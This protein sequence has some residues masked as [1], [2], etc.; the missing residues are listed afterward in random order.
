MTEYKKPLPSPMPWSKPFWDG[1]SQGKLLVQKCKACSR[2]VFYPKLFC[3]FC[4]SQEL[5]WIEAKG[6]GKVYTFTVVYAYQPTEFSEDVP[7]IV[8]V[9]D[10]D[11]GVR[12]MSNIVDC[13]PEEVRCDMEV[14]VVFEKATEE[15]TFPKFRPVS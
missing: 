4:L 5:E 3:P 2:P 1:C 12:L 8:A 13:K 6:T 15:V 11:E 9:I 14:E 7:Y 10:L